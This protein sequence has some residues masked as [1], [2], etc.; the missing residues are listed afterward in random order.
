MPFTFTRPITGDTR[1]VDPL[2]PRLIKWVPGV[3]LAS[4]KS[5]IGPIEGFP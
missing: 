2:N 5:Q 3:F 4:A 1:A